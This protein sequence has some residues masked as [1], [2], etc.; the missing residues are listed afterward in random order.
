MSPISLDHLSIKLENLKLSFVRPQAFYETSS[1]ANPTTPLI[2]AKTVFI[3]VDI[4]VV[5]IIS[6]LIL[7][8]YLLYRRQLKRKEKFTRACETTEPKM[9]AESNRTAL[10]DNHSACASTTSTKEESTHTI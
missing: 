5:A 6:L 8:G 9:A 2:T 10:M 3:L 1:S 4:I 7:L